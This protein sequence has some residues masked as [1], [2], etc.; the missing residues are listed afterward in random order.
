MSSEKDKMLAGQPYDAWDPILCEDRMAAK[1]ACHAFNRADPNDLEGR[2]AIL[3]SLLEMRGKAHLEPTFFCDY[4]YNIHLGDNFYANHNLVVLDGCRVDI[5]NNVKFGP[6][7]MMST[8]THPI[9]PVERRTVEYALPI[10]IGDD[11][12]L[13]GNVSVLPGVTIG[14]GSVIG[15]GSVVTRD[16]PAGVVAVGNPC[17]ELRQIV[18]D[19]H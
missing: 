9:D 13:G 7:V 2:M 12:W 17:R 8:A 16:I 6:N 11:V 18:V 1:A 15:A 3:R 4:G 14:D 10:R 19:R 5:G